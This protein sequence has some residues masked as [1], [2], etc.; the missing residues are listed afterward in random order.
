MLGSPGTKGGSPYI[1]DMSDSDVLS[2][3]YIPLGT[4]DSGILWPV[5]RFTT[6][7]PAVNRSNR[8]CNSIS[9]SEIDSVATNT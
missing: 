1:V 8:A 2:V 5:R 9:D 4:R 7:D 3:A 6:R